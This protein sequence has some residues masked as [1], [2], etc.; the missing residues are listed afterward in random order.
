MCLEKIGTDTY[1]S[2]SYYKK[3]RCLSLFFLAI[4][5]DTLYNKQLLRKKYADKENYK[6]TIGRITY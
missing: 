2:L 6:Q 1:F 3:N 5:L 4:M